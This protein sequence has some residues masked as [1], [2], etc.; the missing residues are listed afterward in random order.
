MYASREDFFKRVASFFAVNSFEYHEIMRA[1]DFVEKIFEGDF[2]EDDSPYIEHLRGTA[3]IV[4]YSG[5]T[6]HKVIIAALLHDVLENHPEKCSPKK[7][8]KEFGARVV[9]LVK[10]VT[11]PLVSDYPIKE[12]R[13][14]V[15]HCRFCFATSETILLK[16]GDRL[17]N[18]LTLGDCLP[19]KR[20]RTIKDTWR[21]YVPFAEE[22]GILYEELKE[23]LIKA[24]KMK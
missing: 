14:H 20:R 10:F 9:F 4:L 15:F 6:D 16:L 24:E 12:E 22:R 11:K 3:L 5:A 2:R 13:D 23:A 7:I 21:Y 17:H 18:V 19:D 1:H 8:K